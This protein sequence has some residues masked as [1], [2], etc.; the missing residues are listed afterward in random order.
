MDRNTVTGFILIAAILVVYSM[1][2]AKQ[3]REHEEMQKEAAKDSLT[4]KDYDPPVTYL[5]TVKTSEPAFAGQESISSEIIKD[6]TLDVAQRLQDYGSFYESSTGTEQFYTLENEKLKIT[7]S[8]K[9]G[10]IYSAELKEYQTSDSLPLILFEGEE[11]YQNIQF[12]IQNN[13]VINTSD[14]Y[15]D[16][17]EVSPREDLITF[18]LNAGHNQYFEQTYELNS[19]KK[20]DYLVDYNIKMVGFENIIPHNAN[21]L[22]LYW[23]RDVRQL[24]KDKETENRYTEMHYKFTEDEVNN[25]SATGQDEESLS[26][27]IAWISFKQQFFSSALIAEKGFQGGTVKSSDL[28]EDGYL[29]EMEASLIL[30][31]NHEIDQEY[32]MQYYLGPNHYQTLKAMKNDM[33]EI[34]MITGF[35]SWV[36][37]INKWIIIPIFNFLH[38]Y[39]ASYGIIIL[40]LTLIIKI[41]LFPLTYKSY[42]SSAMMK[43]LKPELDELKAKYKDDQQKFASA[44]WKLFKSAGVS[45]LGGCLPMVLQMPILIA[46]YY[47]FPTSIELRQESFLWAADLSTYD[48]ILDLP[49][50]VPFYG[51]H[52]SLFTLLM[53]VSSIL[54]AVTNPQMSQGP[55]SMKYMPYIFPVMLLGI[56]NSFPAALTYYYFLA[57]IISYLQ[58]F[59]IKKFIIDDE[60]LHKK[61]QENKKKPV[62]TS[63]FQ[64][65]LEKMTKQQRELQKQ[66]GRKK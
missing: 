8:N 51:D 66:R 15:F 61:I 14:L 43:V 49:F 2:N 59:I 25:L 13:R 16:A 56:F 36:S 37:V 44:Q 23:K 7:L 39:I 29:K 5:D 4:L 17:V 64:K 20:E 38:Q 30:T 32:S 54:Y 48:S 24:E 45:P 19:D 34:V 40:I 22:N 11:N 50:N 28:T 63:G 55:A 1:Y 52:V 18:R 10:R 62:K 21:Y 57:N 47:F 41:V 6:S 26:S 33:D 12:F 60:A 9:G 58:Q 27:S 35:M 46:M 53:T 42:K 3:M 65:R 31:Y